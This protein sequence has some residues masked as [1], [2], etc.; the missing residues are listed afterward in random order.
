[1]RTARIDH[2][3][4]A[5]IDPG[6][7]AW[8]A[9]LRQDGLTWADDPRV[10][11]ALTALLRAPAAT[12][13]VAWR[14][15]GP[16]VG[17]AVALGVTSTLDLHGQAMF[18]AWLIGAGAGSTV[19]E[20]AL[21][22]LRERGW[23]PD[24]RVAA[25]DAALAR[26]RERPFVLFLEG[27]IVEN[28]PSATWLDAQLRHL[29]AARAEAE[30][31]LGAIGTTLGRMAALRADLGEGGAD[32]HVAGLQEARGAEQALLERI[33][34]L[35]GDLVRRREA[36][37]AKRATLAKRAELAALQARASALTKRD[38][39]AP[40]R[41]GAEVEVDV[42]DLRREADALDGR[43]RDESA[44]RRALLAATR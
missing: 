43:L 31:R 14:A 3:A 19:G 23:V 44:R 6:S 30:D 9:Q 2:E 1:M 5:A 33:A 26:L 21:R 40:E 25:R 27:T 20:I 28:L 18:G 38:E 35:R 13:S 32:P 15:I 37:D 34:R 39:D 41:I 36:L 10:P 11:E 17:F 7:P 16:V 29:D 8:A 42:A 22:V 24:P 4:L 12:P